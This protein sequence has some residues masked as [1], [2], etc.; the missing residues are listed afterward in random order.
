MSNGNYS[1]NTNFVVECGFG[2]LLSVPTTPFVKP[3]LELPTPQ[4]GGVLN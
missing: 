3:N 2:L 1:K 4:S